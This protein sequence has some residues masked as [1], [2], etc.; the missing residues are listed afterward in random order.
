[1]TV[2]A[3]V[4]RTLRKAQEVSGAA[5]I[6][7]THDMAVLAEI[8]HRLVVMYAG[9][10]VETGPVT[11]VFRNPAHP[12]TAGLLSSIPRL[13]MRTKR[14]LPIRG[15]PPPLQQLPPGCAF[16]PRCGLAQGR[17]QCIDDRPR[18]QVTGEGRESACHFHE[19]ML[20]IA[21]AE[22]DRAV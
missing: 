19:E 9:R 7:I 17:T 2:Q 1:M 15:Q 22:R 5:M 10:V 3:Q 8:A 21:Q 11:D 6:L 13:D 18:L 14:L 20:S 4:L 16:Q 12:Y